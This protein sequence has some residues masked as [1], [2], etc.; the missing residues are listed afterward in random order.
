MKPLKKALF[1]EVSNCY[2]LYIVMII[3]F[4]AVNKD[5][6]ETGLS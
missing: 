1:Y 6:K 4:T 3:I 2:L 5:N